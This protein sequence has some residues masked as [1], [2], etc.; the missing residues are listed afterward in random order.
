[1]DDM[2]YGLLFAGAI[3]AGVVLAVVIFYV[4]VAVAQWRIFSKAGEAGW[5]GLIPIYN[6]YVQ[7]KLTW[8]TNM[9]WALLV[10]ELLA[11]VIQNTSS[12]VLL[13][14][15]GGVL[16]IAGFV[17][18]VIGQHK[19]SKAFG[20]GVGFTLGLI[21]LSPIFLLILGF[22]SSQYMGNLSWPNQARL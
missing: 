14:L 17:I 8:K 1:M 2:M 22:G 12:S 10:V 19:L 16:S 11:A 13:S 21:F 18:I 15:I 6:T 3:T 7:Y 4:L 20:H 5:K 9:F